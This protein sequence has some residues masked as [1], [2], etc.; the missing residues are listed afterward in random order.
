MRKKEN[1]VC[2]SVARKCE[3]NRNRHLSWD[4]Q[5]VRNCHAYINY[6][7]RTANTFNAME[8]NMINNQSLSKF[9]NAFN[10]IF[11]NIFGRGERNLHA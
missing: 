5:M 8:G 1:M 3:R 7:T 10:L 6:P 2:R 11:R 4:M 9:L